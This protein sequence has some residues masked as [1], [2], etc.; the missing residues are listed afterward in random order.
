MTV[1][2]PS[3]R[4]VGRYA[5]GETD[6]A[7]DEVWAVESHLESCAMCRARLAD[8][9]EGS[10]S[11]LLDAVWTDLEPMLVP[12]PRPRRTWARGLTAWVAPATVP[13]LAMTLAVVVLAVVFDRLAEVTGDQVSLV[14]LIAPVL[15]VL[16]VAA[17][18]ARG[19]D[20]MHELVASTPRAGLNLLLRRTTSVLVVVIPALLAA[21]WNSSFALWLVPC[22]AFTTAT[23]ALGGL[24]GIT[25]AAVALVAVW[26]AVIVAPSVA[27]NRTSF[28]LHE[29]GLPVW[30]AL[31][32]LGAVV[33]VVRKG[34]YSESGAQR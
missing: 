12:Q 2:H 20:P 13:W 10:T 19:L 34:A 6:I 23:L 1:E 16:G 17:S 33:V 26:A 27:L 11:A 7:A 18:W 8:V 25:R 24:V 14:L 5:R 29:G 28:A 4:L 15:P 3:E 30:G 9:V 32:V 31:F 21:G 22:L